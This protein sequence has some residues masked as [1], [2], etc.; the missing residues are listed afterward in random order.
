MASRLLIS[1]SF[2]RKSWSEFARRQSVWLLLV[3]L[4]QH[5]CN[6]VLLVQHRETFF[7]DTD[8]TFINVKVVAQ[9]ELRLH[10]F[11]SLR[12]RLYSLSTLL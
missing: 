12:V 1:D 6:I 3:P 11:A 8:S 10:G 7:L 9:T 4:P 5:V 2:L